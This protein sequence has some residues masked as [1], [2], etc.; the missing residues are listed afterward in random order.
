MYFIPACN[1][2][3][4]FNE[5]VSSFY[6]PIEDFQA[7]IDCEKLIWKLALQLQEFCFLNP[8]M[9]NVPQLIQTSQLIKKLS[10]NI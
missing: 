5:D 1:T 9:T 6:K 2:V 4:S 8:L 10:R 3:S 7:G